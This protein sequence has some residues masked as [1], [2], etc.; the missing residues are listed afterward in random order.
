MK[1]CGKLATLVDDFDHRRDSETEI[2]NY[3][4]DLVVCALRMSNTFPSKT[5]D[6][7]S[8]VQNR[9]ETKNDVKLIE[10]D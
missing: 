2:G 6:L 1:A 7:Q 5:L 3:V 10:N 8:L 4:A 9:I